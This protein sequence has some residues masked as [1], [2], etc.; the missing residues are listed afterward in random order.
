M[1]KAEEILRKMNSS[2]RKSVQPRELSVD[3]PKS[4]KGDYLFYYPTATGR[5]LSKLKDIA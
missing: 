5:I 1:P 4:Q 3:I 2:P